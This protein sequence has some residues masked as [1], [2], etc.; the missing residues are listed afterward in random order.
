MV[1]HIICCNC[2]FVCVRARAPYLELRHPDTRI[3]PGTCKRSLRISWMS[4]LRS[5]FRFGKNLFELNVNLAGTL[6]QIHWPACAWS[7]TRMKGPNLPAS[8]ALTQS[9]LA[10]R[11]KATWKTEKEEIMQQYLDRSPGFYIYFYGVYIYTSFRWPSCQAREEKKK[12][13]PTANSPRRRRQRSHTWAT[14]QRA[15]PMRENGGRRY[16]KHDGTIASPVGCS[17]Q[18]PLSTPVQPIYCSAPHCLSLSLSLPI[19]CEQPRHPGYRPVYVGF[20][21]DL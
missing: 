15:L 8:A 3:Y 16:I 6:I 4:S 11:T 2:P 17:W 5:F 1:R 21:Y 9:P 10:L 14:A 7:F 13:S 12:F 18:L 20:P 19:L